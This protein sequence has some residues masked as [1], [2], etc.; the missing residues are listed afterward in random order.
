MKANLAVA[1]EQ[2]ANYEMIEKEIDEAIVG[3]GTLNFFLILGGGSADQ[4]NIYL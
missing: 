3:M 1:K 4:D 2:L